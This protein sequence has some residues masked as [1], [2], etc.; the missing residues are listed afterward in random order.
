MV[1]DDY[2]HHPT[3]IAAVIAAAR[4]MNR[5]L[6]VMFQPHRYSRTAQLMREFGAALSGAD[7]IV[8]TDIYPGR[9][10]TDSRRDGGGAGGV[11]ERRRA[12]PGARGDLAR[13][14]PERRCGDRARG[15]SARHDGCGIDRRRWATE[16]WRNQSG[17][18][19]SDS[20]VKVKAPSEKNF[21]RAK[22]KPGRAKRSRSRIGWKVA[23]HVA[24]LMLFCYASYRAVESGGRVR[25][26][27]RSGGSW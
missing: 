22:V 15:R 8:L 11:G 9:G 18:G 5:R 16:S 17:I 6:V 7:E 1:I 14:A 20:A 12:G 2:G 26:R 3:E 10:D 24:A 19:R 13:C 23:R 27:S 21:R 4:A 25:R